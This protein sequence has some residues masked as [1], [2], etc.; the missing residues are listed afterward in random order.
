MTSAR[1]ATCLD[2]LTLRSPDA[3]VSAVPYLLGFTP[4]ESAVVVWLRQRR[5][6]LTQRL[7]LPAVAQQHAAWL[8]VLWSHDAARRADE[9]VLVVVSAAP[10][11]RDLIEAFVD[12][13]HGA[14]VAVRDLLRVDAGRWWSLLCSDPDC[15][16]DEGRPV[17]PGVAEMIAAEFTILGRAPLPDRESVVAALA[18]DPQRAAAV[19]AIGR[20]APRH[21]AALERWRSDRLALVSRVVLGQDSPALTRPSRVA[22]MLDGL[23]DIRVRDTLLWDVAH[24]EPDSLPAVFDALAGLLRAAPTGRVAPVATCC[25]VVA[26]LQGDGA[27]AL[28]AI[29]RALA[30]DPHYS[31]AQ[32]VGASLQSGLPPATW[33]EAMAGLA[34]DDCRHGPTGARG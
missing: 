33:R 21:G 30:D 5:I 25:A 17:A 7:D 20:E 8:R 29:E 1:H 6:L 24:R 23:A 2:T 3:L 16:P 19:H 14:G 32:L 22:R 34:R 10:P 11:N 9:L 18:E 28:M 12:R 27:R 4:T 31:L 13:A 15:C 26:W